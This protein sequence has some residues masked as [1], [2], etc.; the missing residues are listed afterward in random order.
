VAA[1]AELFHRIDEADSAEVRRRAAALGLIER[2]ALRN[3]H[4]DSHASALTARG[5]SGA[6]PALWD[7][8]ALHQGRDAVLS[9]LERLARNAGP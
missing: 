4:F 8:A 5:G 7:G 9:A 1:A 3:V 2:L 6:T